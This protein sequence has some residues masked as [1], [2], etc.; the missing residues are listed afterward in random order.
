MSK[1]LVLIFTFVCI[2]AVSCAPSNTP[3]A[4]QV[5]SPSAT[6]AGAGAFATNKYRNLFAG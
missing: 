4:T 3:T 6:P 5:I 2:L 1:E